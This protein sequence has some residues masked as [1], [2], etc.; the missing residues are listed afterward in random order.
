M[1]LSSE[2]IQQLRYK[3]QVTK[4]KE[5]L[6]SLFLHRSLK[7]FRTKVNDIWTG[8]QEYLS[9][10]KSKNSIPKWKEEKENEANA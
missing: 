7:Q 4:V 6:K 8:N 5:C 10:Y 3:L 1:S 9:Y 2:S